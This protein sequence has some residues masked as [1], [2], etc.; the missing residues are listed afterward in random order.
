MT[1]PRDRAS[2]FRESTPGAGVELAYAGIDTFLD[3]DER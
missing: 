3:G 1:A 2:A